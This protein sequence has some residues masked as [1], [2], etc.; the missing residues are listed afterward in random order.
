MSPKF[1]TIGYHWQI[2]CVCVEG[3]GELGTLA[4]RSHF[5]IFMQFSAKNLP[6][7][8]F[9]LQNKGSAHWIYHI[10]FP[11]F[12]FL[13][14]V[15]VPFPF[16]EHVDWTNVIVTIKGLGRINFFLRN[17]LISHSV[18]YVSDS[19][20]GAYFN[21]QP[22]A[23]MTELLH[24]FIGVLVFLNLIKLIHMLRFN[25][26]IGMLAATLKAAARDMGTGLLIILTL[27]FN[28]FIS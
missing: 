23:F 16:Q 2:R 20:S 12:H 7:Y 15:S 22:L 8:W 21:F 10:M 6:N 13:G 27:T 24:G 26:K 4:S 3:G 17:S 5:F 14:S 11:D 28:I 9:S 19:V 18:G 1:H 25:R